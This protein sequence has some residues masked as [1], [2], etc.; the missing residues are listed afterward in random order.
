LQVITNGKSVK[1]IAGAVAEPPAGMMEIHFVKLDNEDIEPSKIMHQVMIS[2][3]RQ[4]PLST[5]YALISK[6]YVPLLRQ[7]E[8]EAGNE[9]NN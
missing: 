4:S 3:I 8:K 5:L 7:G 9:K 6:I 1:C 2:S